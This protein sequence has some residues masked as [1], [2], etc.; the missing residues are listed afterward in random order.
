MNQNN[1]LPQNPRMSTSREFRHLH[2]DLDHAVVTLLDQ[3]VG[4]TSKCDEKTLSSL[5]VDI[6][7]LTIKLGVYENEDPQSTEESH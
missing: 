4:I 3:V 5:V 6:E 1:R 7:T 2:S